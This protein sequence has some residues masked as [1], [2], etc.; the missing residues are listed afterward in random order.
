MCALRLTNIF[1]N[2]TTCS[3][4]TRR[5]SDLI[6]SDMRDS[7]LI[8][9]ERQKLSKRREE[10]S[11][12]NPGDVTFFVSPERAS[13]EESSEPASLGR[14]HSIPV[15]LPVPQQRRIPQ[16]YGGRSVSV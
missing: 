15:C 3:G 12:T 14:T 2:S 16:S 10:S 11:E 8:G 13:L 7:P 1:Q 4:A 6:V 9:L 5:I